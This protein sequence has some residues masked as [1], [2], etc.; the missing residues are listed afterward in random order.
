MVDHVHCLRTSKKLSQES[1]LGINRAP[2]FDFR[3]P[4]ALSPL[5]TRLQTLGILTR[6][7]DAD[8]DKRAARR[9]A[10]SIAQHSTN[11]VAHFRWKLV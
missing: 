4:L 2:I 3:L 7:G 5:D 8:L 6:V 10:Q 9:G 11:E 1:E